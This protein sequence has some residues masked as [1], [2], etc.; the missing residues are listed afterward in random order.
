MLHYSLL[1]LIAIKPTN[2]VIIN[3]L[4]INQFIIPAIVINIDPLS[5]IKEAIPKD[6]AVPNFCVAMKTTSIKPSN[7]EGIH[8]PLVTSLAHLIIQIVIPSVQL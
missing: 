3:A 8:H 1:R 6:L 2:P 7:I 4:A 5:P